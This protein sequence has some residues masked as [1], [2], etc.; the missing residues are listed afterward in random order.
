[1]TLSVYSPER[2][3]LEA[4]KQAQLAY[5][6]GEIPVGAVVVANNRIIAR[7]YNQVELLNDPT[8]HAEIL[9][10]TSAAE[11]LGNKYLKDCTM[12]VTLEPCVM[13]AGALNWAQIDTLYYGA[14]DVKRG[15]S[16]VGSPILH[17]KTKINS[18]I[19]ADECQQLMEDFFKNLRED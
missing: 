15:F 18:G 13:C 2:Y 12:Y 1:M 4:Y 17:P 5:E 6:H 3:M 19:M 16:M 11:F 7:A 8:A 14:S 9:A 10:I